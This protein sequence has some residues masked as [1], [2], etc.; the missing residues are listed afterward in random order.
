MNTPSQLA[1]LLLRL[2]VG[3]NFV[4][5]HGMPKVSD[6]EA[7]LSSEAVQDFPLPRVLGWFA[8]LSELVGGL[9]ITLGL[10][11]RVAA[12]ALLAT[13]LGAA[14]VVHGGDPWASKE[15]ALGYAVLA[16]FFLAH[17]GGVMSIDGALDRRSRSKSPW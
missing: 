9:M 16:V 4:F 10:Y 8:I 1:I 14:F 15:L 12:A 7:F 17:G 2:W 3:L 5:V 6:A 11:T 13:M